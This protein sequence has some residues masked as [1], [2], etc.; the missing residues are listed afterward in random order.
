MKNSYILLR[1]NIESSSLHI[2]DLLQI[3]L[4]ETDLI[5]VECQSV[6]WQSPNE[7]PEL[8]KLLSADKL[9]PTLK[10]VDEPVENIP[11]TVY[12]SPKKANKNKLVFVELPEK[13]VTAS[14]K[15]TTP[16]DMNKYGNPETVKSFE[17]DKKSNLF[18][19]KPDLPFAEIKEIHK[20]SSAKNKN[21]QQT[22]FG[23]ELP[24]YAK[25]ITL[26]IGLLVIGALL[27]LVVM[28]SDNK[29]KIVLQPLP[30]QP[31]KAIA[32]SEPL[33]PEENDT[34]LPEIFEEQPLAQIESPEAIKK[35]TP[36]LPIKTSKISDRKPNVVFEDPNPVQEKPSKK[37][38]PVNE[39][40]IIKKI[41]IEN[42]SSKVTVKA[43]DYNMGSFGGIKNLEVTLENGSAYLLD[44][45]AVEINYLN[46]EG[47]IV[48]SDKI[49][50]Q[51][52]GPGDAVTLPVKKSK[53]GVKIIL[54]VIKIDSK[55]LSNANSTT[56]DSNNYSKN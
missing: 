40:K 22:I 35:E 21:L 51:S 42:I 48:N 43:N 19:S 15:G 53:R 26:Y 47:D 55:D 38:E 41:P 45:I 46:P 20:H 14:F 9:Q 25:K 13:N 37:I 28:N 27:M 5:W 54:K 34:P 18:K 49:Y 12:D 8:K 31:E 39:T 52:I 56:A 11:E 32:I 17:P 3:G 50:F 6:C 7:V 1:N 10:K 33:E 30:Q 24:E 23:F 4:L 44:K 16:D 36:Q 2:E 29:N